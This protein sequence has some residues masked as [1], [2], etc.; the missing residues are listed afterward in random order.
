M[1]IRSWEVEV[2]QALKRRNLN[3]RPTYS[4]IAFASPPPREALR[5]AGDI[6]NAM[7][8]E[9]WRRVCAHEVF[10]DTKRIEN[11]FGRSLE[12]NYGVS[13]G[14][15]LDL[16][17][18][19][20]TYKLEMFDILPKHSDRW[21]GQALMEM[22]FSIAKLFFPMPGPITMPKKLRK[23]TQREYL[24]AF[25]PTFAIEQYLKENPMLKGWF[26]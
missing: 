3:Y 21:L 11:H 1:D 24:K 6:M 15:F 7:T 4:D 26:G 16:A 2:E 22:E 8:Q 9:F 12:N 17:K 23:L 20:W 14:P 25:A 18:T 19:Y 13:A 5:L 10:G